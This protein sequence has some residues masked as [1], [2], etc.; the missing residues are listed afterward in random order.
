MHLCD[1]SFK[2]TVSKALEKS[3]NT[4]RVTSRFFIARIMSSLIP[5][6]VVTV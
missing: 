6:K 2:Q 3:A 1:D 5:N 4:S